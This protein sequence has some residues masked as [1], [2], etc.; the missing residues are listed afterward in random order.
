MLT[1]APPA[2]AA[3]AR[4]IAD[5]A[6]RV[7]VLGDALLDIWLSG[8]A[9]RVGREA[10]VPVVELR[11]TDF[12]PGGA[13]NV[14]ANLAA[15]GARAELLTVLG[16]DPDADRL[17]AG[18][19]AVGVDTRR[20]PREP[21]RTTAVK[22]R[23]VADGQVLARFD[24]GTR[25][26]LAT[27][28]ADVL[29]AA[30]GAALADGVD[31][32]VVADYGL[33]GVPEAARDVLAHRGDV[34]LIVDAHDLLAWRRCAPDLV[35]PSLAEAAAAIRVDPPP[36]GRVGW[37][38]DRRT[39]LAD[40]LGAAEVAVTV[41]LDGS[42]LLAADGAWYAPA[43]AAAP[44]QR[45][46]GAGDTFTA[47]ATLARCIGAG[48]GELLAIAQAAADVAVG[49]AGTAVCDTPALTTRLAR[50][51]RGRVLDP[52]DLAVV[53]AEHRRA[54]RRI[55]FTNG[56]FDVLHRGHVAYLR[57]AKALG[58]V[59]IVALN[60]DASVAAL[61]GPERPVNPLADRAGVISALDAVDLVTAFAENSPIALLERLRPDVY[62]KG[63][64]YTAQMLPE[65][66]VVERLGGQVRIL[67]YLSDHSTS[68]I[69]DRIRTAGPAGR[70]R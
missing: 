48:A 38:V 5:A 55:V 19:V 31:A 60:T 25:S 53:V 67:D 64:D 49:R 15:L 14:A 28:T 41:D 32:V 13:A 57:Q 52:D 45:S 9:R 46:C 36:D 3:L 59:L 39:L 23:L 69:V 4:R 50:A 29:V 58:D 40:R 2:P 42:V 51:D 24:D 37:V 66:P 62:A 61:K 17:C 6:P 8:P 22:R 56:C 27:A 65:T 35:T 34:P 26:R 54:G 18:L 33:G 12:A 10:P 70:A 44:A 11:N 20:S 63:G 7:L 16:D 47:A 1:A 68:A 43:A 21:R 30:L